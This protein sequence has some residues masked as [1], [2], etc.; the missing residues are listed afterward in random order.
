MTAVWR[1]R[2][3]LSNGHIVEP[4]EASIA[5]VLHST[6]PFSGAV[7]DYKSALQERLQAS[8]TGQPKYVL[9]DQ[10]GPDHQRR[11]RI[12][13]RVDDGAGGTLTLAAAEGSTKKSAQQEAARL[14]FASLLNG[15]LLD[16]VPSPAA[17]AIAGASGRGGSAMSHR[18]RGWR[19]RTRDGLRSRPRGSCR[20]RRPRAESGVAGRDRKRCA[21]GGDGRTHGEA[22]LPAAAI[23]ARPVNHAAQ[24]RHDRCRR[25]QSLL[26]V[27]VIALFIIT[28]MVQPF[29]IPS[30]SMEPTL[31]VGDFLLVDKQAGVE[32]PPT[33]LVRHERRS[34]RRHDRLPLSGGS[35]DASGEARVGMPGDHVQLRDGHAY[36]DGHAL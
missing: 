9:T 30:E 5:S 33:A 23:A 11:F 15:A 7:G 12:E 22:T 4:A 24:H 13:V 19:W 2:G 31:L 32:S 6:E 26:Y 25:L 18:R 36:V 3:S 1:R 14:A 21:R 20:G 29:R 28:F 10:S 17:A 27:M 8:G 35:I 34:P 16:V